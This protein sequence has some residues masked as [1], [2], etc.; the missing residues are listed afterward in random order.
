MLQSV[1]IANG[2]VQAGERIVD[3]GEIID[4]HTYNVL[5]SLKAIHEAKTGARRHKASYWPG[6]SCSSSD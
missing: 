5:R 4:N 3:R 2:M 1:S 6:N